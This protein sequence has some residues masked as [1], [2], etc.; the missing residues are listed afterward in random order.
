MYGK[1]CNHPNESHAWIPRAT[2]LIIIFF[3]KLSLFFSLS[4]SFSSC[5]VLFF[6]VAPLFFPLPPHV[7]VCPSRLGSSVRTLPCSP[8]VL[9]LCFAPVFPQS[10]PLC[11]HFFF[12]RTTKITHHGQKPQVASP[13]SPLKGG[14]CSVFFFKNLPPPTTITPF[15]ASKKQSFFISFLFLFFVFCTRTFCLFPSAP[16]PLLL[17]PF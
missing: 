16:L 12:R 10:S 17:T 6:V 7:V 2:T 8:F 1:K 3:A 5:T 14:S 15:R 9:L 4:L 11:P 13:G